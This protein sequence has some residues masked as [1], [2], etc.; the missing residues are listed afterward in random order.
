MLV[1]SVGGKAGEL[2]RDIPAMAPP[3][4]LLHT[5]DFVVKRYYRRVVVSAIPELQFLDLANATRG[6]PP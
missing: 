5:K 1:L 3:L 4:L 2:R 6:A